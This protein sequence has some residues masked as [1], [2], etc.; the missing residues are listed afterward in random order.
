MTSKDLY[1]LLLYYNYIIPIGAPRN[2]YIVFVSLL[3]IYLYIV[4]SPVGIA[5]GYGLDDR[6]FRVQVM[7]ES[8]MFSSPQR[9]D[10]PWG[11]PSLLSNMYRD[12]FPLG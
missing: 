7:V 1:Y 3:S 11:P 2:L 5:T 10:R 6:G 8:R 4:R 9:P 12:L